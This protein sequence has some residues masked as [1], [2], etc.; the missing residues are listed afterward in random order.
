MRLLS[1]LLCIAVSSALRP[2]YVPSQKFRTW[3]KATVTGAAVCIF[4]AGPALAVAPMLE[5]ALIEASDASYPILRS[6]TPETLNP[7]PETLVGILEKR[8]PADRLTNLIDKGISA[9]L[10][11][12]ETNV[13]AFV[14][15]TEDAT[16]GLSPESC[17]LVPLPSG[18]AARFANLP[19][20]ADVDGA[21]LKAAQERAAPALKAFPGAEGRICLPSEA[22]LEKLFVAQTDISLSTSRFAFGEFGAAAELAG[23]SIPL[24]DLSRLLPQIQ[25]TQ[26]GVDMKARSRFESAGKN[27]DKAIKRDVQ[28]ARLRG[29][30]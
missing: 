27:L 22:G 18:A 3:T 13:A 25:K 14:K 9:F 12:P 21:K 20:V 2:A 29:K 10:S 7:F 24:T 1:S 4:A 11:I 15:A 19:G 23:K 30:I 28:F 16:A 6:L 17:D 26:R 5:A 8:V